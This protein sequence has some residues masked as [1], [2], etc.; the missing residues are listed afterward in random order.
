M[1]KPL[2]I[3]QK[4]EIK[5][6]TEKHTWKETAEKFHVTQMT[7]SR[8]MKESLANNNMHNRILQDKIDKLE[9]YRQGYV[10]YNSLFEKVMEH[11]NEK[12]MILNL[13]KEV[14]DFNLLKQLEK[15]MII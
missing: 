6:Y 7:I 11:S 1:T 2:S 13:A 3:E 15:E 10:Q 4:K 14:L 9:K 12:Q 8:I 5:E